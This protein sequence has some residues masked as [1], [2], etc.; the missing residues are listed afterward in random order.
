MNQKGFVS[1]LGML[2]TLMIIFF[3]GYKAFG[4]YLN[5]PS[6]RK[7]DTTDQRRNNGG[8]YSS[9]MQTFVDTKEKIND[10]NKMSL[11]REGLFLNATKE[12]Y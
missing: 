5:K 1:I 8:Y 4:L 10:I 9:R 7:T 6:D 3:L 2:L 12:G 11:E